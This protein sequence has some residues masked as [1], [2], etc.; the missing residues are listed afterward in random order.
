MGARCT[1][2][3]VLRERA[4]RMRASGQWSMDELAAALHVSKRSLYRMLPASLRRGEIWVWG[5][6]GREG[7]QSGLKRWHERMSAAGLRRNGSMTIRDGRAIETGRREPWP[8]V[9]RG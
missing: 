5:G 8:M 6:A 3:W 9:E 1:D 2:D 4:A 7:M